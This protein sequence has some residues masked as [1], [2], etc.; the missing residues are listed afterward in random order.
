MISV[1]VTTYGDCSLLGRAIR[2]AL[3]QNGVQVELVV[4][5]DNDPTSSARKMTEGVMKEFLDNDRVR[6]VKHPHNMNGSAARNTGLR[7]CAGEY[8]T[9]LDND[10]YYLPG[11]LLASYS[12]LESNPDKD[13]AFCGVAIM[14]SKT[15][16]IKN[17]V[18]PDDDKLDQCNLL[19]NENM[20]GTGSN[21]FFRRSSCE[22]VGLFDTSFSRNQDIEYLFRFFRNHS[23]IAS[24]SIYIIKDVSETNNTPG[25]WQ[26]RETKTHFREVFGPDLKSLPKNVVSQSIRNN[27][28]YAWSLAIQS[29]S[30]CVL[31]AE[32]D[33]LDAE[34]VI[35]DRFR[36]LERGKA[37]IKNKLTT[38]YSLARNAKLLFTQPMYMC[39]LGL[40][41]YLNIV[42]TVAQ[43]R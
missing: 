30:D 7:L 9:F 36:R 39:R 33:L 2:S 24:K 28:I 31:Q 41:K 26:Y 17:I 13:A 40:R 16:Y 35:S 19:V 34:V 12:L 21:L 20:I 5:D 29:G 10:D 37:L 14:D 38:I 18:I 4:V 42:T 8:I 11:R 15:A 25:F 1:I 27:A 32:K 6:Y 3:C 23:A 43:S 22:D